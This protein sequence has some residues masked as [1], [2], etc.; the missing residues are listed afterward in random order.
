MDKFF[1]RLLF[2]LALSNTYAQNIQ[3][4]YSASG[5]DRG[6][7]IIHTLDGGFA[8]AGYTT[9]FGSGGHDFFVLKV[10]ISGNIQ[11]QKTYGGTGDEDGTSIDID[12]MSDSSYVLVGATASFG[13]NSLDAY[14]LRIDKSGTLLWSKKYNTASNSEHFRGVK[15]T[16]NDEILITGTDNADNF[17]SGDGLVMRVDI[18]GNEIWKNVYGGGV[19]D[20]FHSI[21]ELPG[22]NILITGSTT[23]YG[24]GNTAGYVLKLSNSGNILWDYSYGAGG[25][26]AYNGSTLTNDNKI[27]CVGFTN[28]FGTGGYQVLVTKLDTNGVV[29]WSKTYGGSNYERGVAIQAIPNSTDLYVAANTM[30][31][32]NGGDE[33]LIIRINSD[34][35]VVWSK[36]Y[37]TI[38]SD[39]FD[40]WAHSSLTVTNSGACALTGWSDGLGNNTNDI[41]LVASDETGSFFCDN[42]VLNVLSV[43]ITRE[44]PTGGIVS[45][46]NF[47]PVTTNVTDAMFQAETSCVCPQT[48][49]F[50]QIPELCLNDIAPQLPTTSLNGIDG[51]WSPPVISTSVAGVFSY[52]FTPESNTC[53]NGASMSVSVDA[54]CGMIEPEFPVVYTPSVTAP[55]VITPNNDGLNDYFELNEI[56]IAN[57]ELVIL[58]R[59]GNVMFEASSEH[60]KWDGKV[61]GSFAT[62]GT[63]FYLYK[64]NG[65][66]E[67]TLTGHGFFELIRE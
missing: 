32:G 53:T 8:I 28:S 46:G 33:L 7:S 55:N 45:T 15:I 37:G 66:D 50:S 17:G 48:P 9:S 62:E 20:H 2:V 6:H 1:I 19:N 3:R 52:N 24:P 29:L 12:Q 18:D 23:S 35:N 49:V 4:S 25:T 36:T 14:V 60:P 61:N 41:L 57:V 64:A 38:N 27:I 44:D 63:Y 56:D 16:A 65:K 34:G 22:G 31:Y 26:D 42:V 59:W 47:N 51:T 13:S 39:E 43:N 40:S 5:D 10:D 54:N 58:N 11:W 21:E 30:S 67:T